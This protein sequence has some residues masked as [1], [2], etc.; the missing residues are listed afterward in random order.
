MKSGNKQLIVDLME[1]KNIFDCNV[2]NYEDLLWM[3]KDRKFYHDVIDVL[4]R[5]GFYIERVWAYG[6]YHQDLP[7]IKELITIKNPT[8]SPPIF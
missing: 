8:K 3:L 6:L 5:R 4:K 1:N 2:F 7:T